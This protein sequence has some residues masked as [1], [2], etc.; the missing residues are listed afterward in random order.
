MKIIPIK[1][2]AKIAIVA[3]IVS[4][5]F[6]FCFAVYSGLQV[7]DEFAGLGAEGLK[8]LGLNEG[9]ITKYLQ[10]GEEKS[11]LIE[12]MIYVFSYPFEPFWRSFIYSFLINLVLI[13]IATSIFYV[14]NTKNES[15]I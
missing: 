15:S 7:L 1:I 3:F 5:I 12:R 6:H 13:M 10:E 9:Q 8:A 14:W 11:S 4:F 2:I